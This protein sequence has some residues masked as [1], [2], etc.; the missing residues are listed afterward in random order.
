MGGEFLRRII[1][2]VAA[3]VMLVMGTYHVMYLA[4]S[5]EGRLWVRDMFPRW[6]DVKDLVGNFAYH[7]GVSK[8]K[9]E[10]CALWLR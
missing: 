4:F 1:H 10:D 9:A 8:E 6:K 5:K 3:V 2:R 7:L